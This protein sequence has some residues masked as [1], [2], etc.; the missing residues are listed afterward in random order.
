MR[1]GANWVEQRE[2]HAT[3]IGADIQRE[4][5]V[6]YSALD[7]QAVLDKMEAAGNGANLK[8]V[9]KRVRSA[10]RR[11]SDGNVREREELASCTLSGPKGR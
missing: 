5:E 6:A 11:D 9:F 8:D 10:V 4:D 7:A 3:L 2:H 1:C